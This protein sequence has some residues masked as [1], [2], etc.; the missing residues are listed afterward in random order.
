[1][2]QKTTL[3]KNEPSG[4]QQVESPQNPSRKDGKK[5]G[6]VEMG[7]MVGSSQVM[8]DDG[9]GQAARGSLRLPWILS[10]MHKRTSS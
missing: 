6:V 1:M 4:T 3:R 5:K 2:Q 7:V 10:D 9:T 8:D